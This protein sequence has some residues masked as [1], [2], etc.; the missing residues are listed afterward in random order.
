MAKAKYKQGKDGFWRTKAWDGTYNPNG[1]KHRINLKSEKSSGDLEKQVNALKEKVRNR[2][3]VYQT[4]ELFIDYAREWLKTYKKVRER[5]T[6]LMYENI[7]E[8]HL[9]LLQ[10]Y[11]LS[12]LTIDHISYV[13]NVNAGHPRTCQQIALTFRQ[14]IKAAIRSRK[15]PSGIYDELCENIELPTYIPSPKR[16]LTPE[17]V[18]AVKTANFTDKERCFVYIIY[19]CGL[20]REEVLALKAFDINFKTHNL[21][22]NKA[23]AF[24]GNKPYIKSPKSKNGVRCV[25][26]PPFVEEYLSGYIPSVG[27]KYLVSSKNGGMMTLSGYRRMWESIVRKMNLAAGGSDTFPVISG[28]TAHLFRHNYCTQLCY[29]VPTI[30][31]K[32]IAKLMGDSEKMVLDVYSHVCEDKEN[33]STALNNAINF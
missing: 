14:I 6:Q 1:T 16:P 3:I 20:R 9:I 5:N 15:L 4:D 2:D 30:S 12:E 22:V 8:K 10:H 28:L 23:L 7:I 11:R 25:P 27:D 33:V 26:L 18:A 13:V 21:T 17:E 19:G 24:E 32:M 29:Q 31:T